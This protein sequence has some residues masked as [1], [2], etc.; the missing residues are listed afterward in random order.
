MS[1]SNDLAEH[2]QFVR[3]AANR[4][5]FLHRA[6]THALL[7]TDTRQPLVLKDALCWRGN[8]PKTAASMDISPS[9]PTHCDAWPDQTEIADNED[10]GVLRARDVVV[11]AEQPHGQGERDLRLGGRSIADLQFQMETAPDLA[12]KPVEL[13]PMELKVRRTG[14]H[15]HGF[16]FC[17]GARVAVL[18]V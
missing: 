3:D 8:R 6:P 13:D 2:A 16:Q 10:R 5:E 14:K 12:V 4:Q 11:V 9:P 1:V 17:R 18:A 15:A 7:K